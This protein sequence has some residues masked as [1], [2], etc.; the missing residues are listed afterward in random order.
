MFVRLVVQMQNEFMVL[1]MNWNTFCH[2]FKWDKN[3]TWRAY[4]NNIISSL[5][6]HATKLFS[7]QLEKP[8]KNSWRVNAKHKFDIS[9]KEKN[10]HEAVKKVFYGCAEAIILRLSDGGLVVSC[11]FHSP[12][13]SS[14]LHL[15]Q[16][17]CQRICL[18]VSNISLDNK[19][20]NSVNFYFEFI[21]FW[22]FSY[23]GRAQHLHCGFFNILRQSC[24]IFFSL[25][26]FQSSG[27]TDTFLH[28]MYTVLS[29][30]N[31]GCCHRIFHFYRKLKRYNTYNLYRDCH[32]MLYI[33][34]CLCT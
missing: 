29:A 14:S 4:K 16:N 11:A 15:H 12:F 19:R 30:H 17:K 2:R 26:I 18:S 3:Q 23:S 22:S 28:I 27:E 34:S 8:W 6:L 31:S 7:F 5:C 24:R 33:V 13:L 25:L 21:F 10:G 20:T 1:L 32:C 9:D